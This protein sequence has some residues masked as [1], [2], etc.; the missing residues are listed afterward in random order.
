VPLDKGDPVARLGAA[1]AGR[2]PCL[3]I[4]D[5]FEQ[6]ARHAE[7]TVGRWLDA[8]S[9]ACFLVTSREVLGLPGEQTYALAPLPDS[10]ATELFMR[11][12]QAAKSG[13]VL[14]A[15]DRAAVAPL[16]KLLDGLPLA[17][18]LAAAR[19][20]VMPPHSVLAHMGERFRLLASSGGRRDR[21]ATLRAAFD[22]SW[23]LLSPAERS[24][25][26]QLSVF[27]DGFT[28]EAVEAVVDLSACDGAP[29]IV[30]VLQSLLDKSLVRP[31]RRERFDLLNSVQAYAAEQLAGEGR[32]PGSGAAARQ[33]ANERHCAWFAALG[34]KRAVEDS[35]AELSNLVIACRRAIASS[36]AELAVG[37]LQGAWAALKLHGPYG[38]GL[39]LGQAVCGLPGLSSAAAA[40]AQAIL[41]IALDSLGRAAE[42]RRHC[43]IALQL[44]RAS[45]DRACVAD[46]VI[47][48][49]TLDRNDGRTAEARAG[50]AEAL[51]LA[52]QL[53]DAVSECAALNGLAS[54][55][56]YQGRLDEARANYE[57][58]LARAR[59]AGDLGWQCALLGNLGM[60]CANIGRME[61]AKR[62]FEQSL[63]LARGLGDRQGEGRTLCN[64]GMLH[65]VQKRPD[66]AIEVSERALRVAR[67]LGHLRVEG[68]VQCNL[69][70][71]YEE[72]GNVQE[73]MLRFDAALRSMR[74]L[75]DHR[76]EGQV[77]GYLG[78]TRARQGDFDLAREDFAAGQALLKEVSD[79]FSLGILLCDFAECEFRSGDAK[80]ARR[81]LEEARAIVASAS[82][83]PQSEL[84]QALAR[85]ESLLDSV[86][87]RVPVTRR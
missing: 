67:D 20:R 59:D 41:G 48:L 31:V 84:G 68:T 6:V 52:R 1:I 21:Q 4:L 28:R 30:D 38:M 27:E 54:V 72:Q 87:S 39:E 32:F 7:Q 76:S 55:D 11:R 37:A 74:E 16:V 75:G 62:C 86:P 9:Q 56:V 45:D 51:T 79:T 49:A 78:R 61:E 47:R 26:A 36:S 24:V 80:A 82:A 65:L 60:L 50:L 5:N 46:V 69:G 18:E 10:E 58:A 22:W 81:T 29:W 53:G 12:A 42:A 63:A 33:S 64:L 44:A 73:A 17:I 35:C 2:G 77:L 70:L 40:R 34:P 14:T 85:V 66:E 13:L 3:V 25:L 43:E 71:A 23:D 19:V 15:E 8:A 83:G 57:A